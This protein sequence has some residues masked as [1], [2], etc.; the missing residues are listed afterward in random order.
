MSST[1]NTFL[2]Y[3]IQF[4]NFSSHC[5]LNTLAVLVGKSMLAGVLLLLLSGKTCQNLSVSSPA[6]VTIVLPSGL[7]AKYKT[8]YVC[9]VKVASFVI[10]G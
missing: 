4:F 7:V 1:K 8:L 10:L 5:Y 9:P 2:V 6:P 3:P